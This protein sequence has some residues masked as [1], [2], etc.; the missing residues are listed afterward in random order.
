MIGITDYIKQKDKR[1]SYN[2]ANTIV[3]HTAGEKGYKHIVGT[4]S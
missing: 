2:T 3:Y 1:T 4:K